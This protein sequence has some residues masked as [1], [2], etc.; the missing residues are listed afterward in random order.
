MQLFGRESPDGLE[1]ERCLP[2][3]RDL[4]NELLRREGYT[5]GRFDSR[6]KG[7]CTRRAPEVPMLGLLL[8]AAAM[9]DRRT[10]FVAKQHVP[11]QVALST[12][13]VLA[14]VVWALEGLELQVYGVD[15]PGSVWMQKYNGY[16]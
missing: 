15:V 12:T 3:H 13:L 16:T 2:H 11:V 5:V 8:T 6:Y 9:H 10:A 4:G 14:R 1:E 7:L